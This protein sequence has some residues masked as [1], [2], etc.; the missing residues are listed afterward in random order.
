M[1]EAVL[2]RVTGRD[3]IA[4]RFMR[5]E[6]FEFRPSFLLMLATNFKPKFKGQDEGLWRRVKLIPWERYFA[7]HERDHDLGETLLDERAG[8]LAWAV[9]GS[10]EWFADGLQDPPIVKSATT[11]YRETSDALAGFLPGT[12]VRDV[13]APR[14][15]G[16]MLFTSY[17]EWA[18][19][20]NLPPKERWTRQTFY[21]ALEERGATK[22]KTAKGVAFEGIRRMRQTDVGTDPEAPRA[23]AAPQADSS[24]DKPTTPTRGPSLADL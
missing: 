13:A 4:A 7:P 22:R 18:D 24:S 6:F 19:A 2:K 3:L 8:I 14:I 9:R 17:L 23:E 16:A 11:E 12:F 1:A 15:D 20:E 5:K 21:G 10:R